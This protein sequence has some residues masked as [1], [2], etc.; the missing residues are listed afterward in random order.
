MEEV[1]VYPLEG[2]LMMKPEHIPIFI[3]YFRLDPNIQ[4]PKNDPRGIIAIQLAAIHKLTY[5][6]G[7]N[8]SNLARLI[9]KTNPEN[10]RQTKLLLE[11][12]R[13]LVPPTRLQLMQTYQRILPMIEG[14]G[15]SIPKY[16]LQQILLASADDIRIFQDILGIPDSRD[17][18][19]SIVLTL[20]GLDKIVYPEGVN[21]DDILELVNETD[22]SNGGYA[23]N[24]IRSYG[25][26]PSDDRYTLMLQYLR[27]KGTIA[28]SPRELYQGQLLDTGYKMT[29]PQIF[30]KDP[31]SILQPG[32]TSIDQAILRLQSEGRLDLEVPITPEILPIL[33]VNTTLPHFRNTLDF[34]QR[35]SDMKL[36]LV[37]EVYLQRYQGTGIERFDLMIQLAEAMN[38]QA[39]TMIEF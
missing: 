31:S 4:L 5:P 6:D 34:I 19:G 27:A 12:N 39:K 1:P 7:I 3:N 24:I 29:L 8:E 35:W 32:E 22:P 14:P 36:E 9:E 16:Q 11:D 37:D 38:N 23:K 30:L 25:M 33:L 15:V 21:S 20:A 17:L 2:V 10:E 28:S 26:T 13:I 18:I